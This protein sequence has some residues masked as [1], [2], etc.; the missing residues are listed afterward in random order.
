MPS[1]KWYILPM[2]KAKKWKH[3]S[4]S[5]ALALAIATALTA[6]FAATFAVFLV[7][8][9]IKLIAVARDF[10]LHSALNRITFAIPLPFAVFVLCTTYGDLRKSL[11]RLH[12]ILFLLRL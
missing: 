4:V 9:L 6:Y 1:S 5:G 7:I 10:K 8:L 2:R 11:T 3:H 12:P